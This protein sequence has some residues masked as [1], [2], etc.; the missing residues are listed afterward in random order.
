MIANDRENFT[1]FDQ[2]ALLQRLPENLDGLG[3]WTEVPAHL[4]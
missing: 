3:P 1:T 2:Y 4:C